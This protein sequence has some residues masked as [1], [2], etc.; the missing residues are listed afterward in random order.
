MAARTGAV[1]TACGH[2]ERYRAATGAEAGGGGDGA[3][4]GIDCA[5]PVSLLAGNGVERR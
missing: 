1:S 2:P 4:T 5:G 3:L